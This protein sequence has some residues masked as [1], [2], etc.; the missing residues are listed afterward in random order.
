MDADIRMIHSYE[1]MGYEC[2]DIIGTIVETT[3]GNKVLYD[4]EDGEDIVVLTPY[5]S[6]ELFRNLIGRIRYA[7]KFQHEAY[8]KVFKDTFYKRL[9]EI[10][11][12]ESKTDIYV[13]INQNSIIG[14]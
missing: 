12:V 9:I 2:A 13:V 8:L 14:G 1:S 7:L 10:T 5:M 11:D 4:I 3:S 6:T